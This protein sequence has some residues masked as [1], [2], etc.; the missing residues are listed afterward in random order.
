V[1]VSDQARYVIVLTT[2]FTLPKSTVPGVI[3][4]VTRRRDYEEITPREIVHLPKLRVQPNRKKLRR[5]L[6]VSPNFLAS[7]F[8]TKYEL[9]S[10][11]ESA[12]KTGLIPLSGSLHTVILEAGRKADQ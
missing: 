7:D 2:A 11:F 10:L 12:E 9:I 8:I 1:S 6:L 5:R 4:V 3:E